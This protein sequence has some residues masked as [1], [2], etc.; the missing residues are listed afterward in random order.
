MVTSIVTAGGLEKG[1]Q[2]GTALDRFLQWVLDDPS[3][4]QQIVPPP[5]W[6]VQ[7]AVSASADAGQDEHLAL[8][9]ASDGGRKES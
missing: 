2:A 5:Y 8:A 4:A 7:Q 9:A 3:R 1:D 6:L